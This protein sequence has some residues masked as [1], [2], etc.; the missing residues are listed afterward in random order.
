LDVTIGSM[1]DTWRAERR[2]HRRDETVGSERA[3]PRVPF[4]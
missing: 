3:A 1:S 2:K 4:T